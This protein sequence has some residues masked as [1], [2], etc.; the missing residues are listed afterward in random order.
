MAIV[1]VSPALVNVALPVASPDKA[2]VTALDNASASSAV[3]VKLPTNP[4]DAVI[5]V[6]VIA[7]AEL[8]PITA[9]SIAPPSILTLL[10]ACVAMFPS[11]KAVLASPALVAPVPPFATGKVPVTSDVR[12][13][14]AALTEPLLIF[15]TPVELLK[16]PP[17]PPY[18]EPITVPC[19]VPA[20][21]VPKRTSSNVEPSDCVRSNLPLPESYFKRPPDLP[22][23]TSAAI[24]LIPKFLMSAIMF[25]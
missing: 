4:E 21:T 19:H 7:A 9:P 3:P 17:S 14:S 15:N 10:L 11:P 16:S 2:T 24:P 25:S 18:V 6:P 12:S 1:A 13:T 5:V 22:I 23:C 8:A 20:P